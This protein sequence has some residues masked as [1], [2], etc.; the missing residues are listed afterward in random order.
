MERVQEISWKI[1]ETRK[2]EFGSQIFWVISV[3][4]QGGG[5]GDFTK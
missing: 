3:F 5:G 2:N 4:P 1:Q